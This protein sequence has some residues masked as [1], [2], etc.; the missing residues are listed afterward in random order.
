[1]SEVYAVLGFEKVLKK[2]CCRYVDHR[3]NRH[4][5][6]YNFKNHSSNLLAAY[7]IH[8]SNFQAPNSDLGVR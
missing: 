3:E 7:L 1:M 6:T 8:F 2:F 4:Q 5:L